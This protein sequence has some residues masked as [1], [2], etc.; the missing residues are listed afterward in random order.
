M[1]W[2]AAWRACVM[3]IAF[4][5]TLATTSPAH[6]Y[7]NDVCR[8]PALTRGYIQYHG[9]ELRKHYNAQ[10]AAL[11]DTYFEI[12]HRLSEENSKERK[13]ITEYYEKT[14][15]AARDADDK[16]TAKRLEED[17]KE[18]RGIVREEYSQQKQDL[19]DWKRA[20]SDELHR[21]FKAR[22]LLIRAS[23]IAVTLP[24]QLR[25]GISLTLGAATAV[26]PAGLARSLAVAETV[27]EPGW[28]TG[29][30]LLNNKA[31]SAAVQFNGLLRQNLDQAWL[32]KN[33]EAGLNAGFS[34][35]DMVRFSKQRVRPSEKFMSG[36]EPIP[37][38]QPIPSDGTSEIIPGQPTSAPAAQS[39]KSGDPTIRLRDMD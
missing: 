7:L 17:R 5:L 19:F 1:S 22:E 8:G 6:A 9:G 20:K 35:D 37:G 18:I 10:K 25:C 29:L 30:G 38:S 26:S 32:D 31:L 21:A 4:P 12:Y 11:E 33:L 3:A 36:F 2:K 39:E 16:A 23:A 34:H 13:Q 14:I 24:G 27:L 15:A 28:E